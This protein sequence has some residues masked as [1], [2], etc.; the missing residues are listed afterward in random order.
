MGMEAVKVV[1]DRE[2]LGVIHLLSSEKWNMHFTF[3]NEAIDGLDPL[4]LCS[5]VDQNTF[6]V[7]WSIFSRQEYVRTKPPLATDNLLGNTDGVL[8]SPPSVEFGAPHQ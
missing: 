5:P 3:V 8:Q 6:Y 2:A 7:R 4:D 1:I